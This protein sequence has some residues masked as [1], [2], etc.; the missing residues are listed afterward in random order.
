MPGGNKKILIWTDLPLMA[1]VWSNDLSNTY[2]SLW[3]TDT[4]DKQ[5]YRHQRWQQ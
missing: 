2:T 4:S 1:P 5:H 3:M